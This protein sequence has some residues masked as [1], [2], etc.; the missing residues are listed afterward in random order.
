MDF[1]YPSNEAISNLSDSLLSNDQ[2]TGGFLDS[3]GESDA[4]SGSSEEIPLEDEKESGGN[5]RKWSEFIL[6][7]QGSFG[8]PNLSTFSEYFLQRLLNFALS[9]TALAEFLLTPDPMSISL[10]NS[11]IQINNLQ[12]DVK[13]LNSKFASSLPFKFKTARLS[14]ISCALPVTFANLWMSS[15]VLNDDEI[16]SNASL[17]VVAQDLFVELEINKNEA[18]STNE[19]EEQKFEY[20]SH[21]ST[22]RFRDSKASMSQSFVNQF[23]KSELADSTEHDYISPKNENSAGLTFFASMIDSIISKLSVSIKNI[24]IRL[25]HESKFSISGKP[26]I[27]SINPEQFIYHMDI[28]LPLIELSSDDIDKF[29]SET[30]C[31]MRSSSAEI[32]RV[33]TFNKF[34]VDLSEISS[35]EIMDPTH[36]EYSSCTRIFSTGNSNIIRQ[37]KPVPPISN[38]LSASYSTVNS[39]MYATALSEHFVPPLHSTTIAKELN[40]SFEYKNDIEIE[41]PQLFAFL[42]PKILMILKEIAEKTNINTNS[43]NSRESKSFDEEVFIQNLSSERTNIRARLLINS[44]SIILTQADTLL[45]NSNFTASKLFSLFG[46]PTSDLPIE[47]QTQ[48]NTLLNAGVNAADAYP[49]SYIA[50]THIRIEIDKVLAQHTYDSNDLVVSRIAIREWFSKKR[51]DEFYREIFVIESKSSNIFGLRMKATSVGEIEIDLGNL[52]L[53]TEY[54]ILTRWEWISNILKNE[55]VVAAP[56]KKPVNSRT[57]KLF[58]R[59]DEAYIFNIGAQKFSDPDSFSVKIKDVTINSLIQQ[60]DPTRTTIEFSEISM[61]LRPSNTPIVNFTTLE[62]NRPLIELIFRRATDFPSPSQPELHE[63]LSTDAEDDDND[64]GVDWFDIGEKKKQNKNGKGF[65]RFWMRQRVVERTL[66]FANI[67]IPLA[68]IRGNKSELDRIQLFFNRLSLVSTSEN[69]PS[70]S[71]SLKSA[72]S[73]QYQHSQKN[74]ETK[75]VSSIDSPGKKKLTF[76]GLA[77][78][79][80]ENESISIASDWTRFASWITIN[81]INIVLDCTQPL[82]NSSKYTLSLKSTTAFIVGEHIGEPVSA[83]FVDVADFSLIENESNTIFVTRTHDSDKVRLISLDK[84]LDLKETTVDVV[85]RGISINASFSTVK[86]IENLSNLFKEPEGMLPIEVQTPLIKLKFTMRDIIID[87]RPLHIPFASVILLERLRVLS[88]L[89]PDSPS[90]SFKVLLQ[91]LSILVLDDRSSFDNTLFGLGKSLL[92]QFGFA[93]VASVNE[94]NLFARLNSGENY[95]NIEIELSDRQ[96]YI[97]TCTDSFNTLTILL[98]YIASGRD[99][100]GE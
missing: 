21:Y 40:Q 18:K 23:Y 44:I 57:L 5:K 32:L 17:F 22:D 36:I 77:D 64:G 28:C 69:Q 62:H 33:L 47:I 50:S 24:V 45:T 19:S 7:L 65:E 12:L 49:A 2:S 71:E 95:P 46:L 8:F 68:T 79:I 75:S 74:K 100:G 20:S 53:N 52:K 4:V 84:I 78:S 86:L 10:N 51:R 54:E 58:L 97:D 73:P 30:W 82:L 85:I 83:A 13:T 88:N 1:T 41:I 6:G 15:T 25:N 42:T 14:S 59:L 16:S 81:K 37:F 34:F 67:T 35:S 89:I 60:Q 63:Y 92:N 61:C 26:E 91:N 98:G 70:P 48:V 39:S 93:N 66:N 11:K 76:Q 9:K 72:A 55:E 38:D 99:F 31:A 94:L 56:E 27:D 90:K 80:S 3:D 43:G 96:M 29:N 87:Y